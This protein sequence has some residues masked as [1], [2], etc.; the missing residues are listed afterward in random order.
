MGLATIPSQSTSGHM[1]MIKKDYLFAGFLSSF[2]MELVGILYSYATG[3]LSISGG[4][5]PQLMI[6]MLVFGLITGVMGGAY[7]SPLYVCPR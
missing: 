1:K 4:L 2:V 6:I 5:F 3:E 7:R